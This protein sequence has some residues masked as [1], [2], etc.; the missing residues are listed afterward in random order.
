METNNDSLQSTEDS[1]NRVTQDQLTADAG[2]GVSAEPEHD[3]A[4]SSREDRAEPRG[5][6]VLM[7]WNP[8][9]QAYE[10]AGEILNVQ[11]LSRGPWGHK[12]VLVESPSSDN[13]TSLLDRE[14]MAI[15]KHTRARA[16]ALAAIRAPSMI[17]KNTA[18]V[19]S[20]DGTILGFSNA[21]VA[22]AMRQMVS[23]CMWDLNVE[24]KL[25]TS[26]DEARRVQMLMLTVT[27]KETGESATVNMEILDR[28]LIRNRSPLSAIDILAEKLANGLK[29]ARQELL[30]GPDV[31]AYHGACD[32]VSRSIATAMHD[33]RLH[34]HDAGVT[35]A[36][37]AIIGNNAWFDL[38]F[39]PKS[40]TPQAMAKWADDHRKVAIVKPQRKSWN[41]YPTE[42]MNE[43]AVDQSPGLVIASSAAAMVVTVPIASDRG[44]F[45]L[46]VRLGSI[47]CNP[48]TRSIQAVSVGSLTGPPLTATSVHGSYYYSSTPSE[49]VGKY[50]TTMS[51]KLEA[52]VLALLQSRGCAPILANMMA[53]VHDAVE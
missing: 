31:K 52:Q 33:L 3:F 17:T 2:S 39:A 19:A 1:A 6:P 7:Q 18:T 16:A 11:G 25:T 53:E 28:D 46:A 48:K 40:V 13:P 34:L 14:A 36:E 49:S 51:R 23:E 21:D 38:H 24:V 22:N 27:R 26:H 12:P 30:S 47:L 10:A 45:L 44:K 15:S 5:R 4:D 35:T 43:L 50:L 32:F 42:V 29:M 37:F 20:S 9:A 41:R 8:R